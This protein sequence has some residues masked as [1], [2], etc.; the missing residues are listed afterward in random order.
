[1]VSVLRIWPIEVERRATHENY[2]DVQLQ[3]DG[4]NPIC[5]R[6]AADYVDWVFNCLTQ[7][8]CRVRTITGVIFI[9]AGLYYC[10]MYI[11]GLSLPG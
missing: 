4:D 6:C 3:E 7:I 8:E 2:S 9:L 5:T 11:Y 1:M 10:L